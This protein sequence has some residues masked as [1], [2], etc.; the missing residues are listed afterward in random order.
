MSVD[1]SGAG[2]PVARLAGISLSYG[3]TLALDNISLDFPASCMVGLIG[4]DGVGKSSLL[5]LLAGARAVQQGHLE[6]LGGDMAERRHRNVVFKLC[7]YID[8]RTLT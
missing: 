3:K 4:P 6:A 2:P 5:A 8:V 1:K 7:G